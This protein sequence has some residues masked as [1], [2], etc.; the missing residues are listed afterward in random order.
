MKEKIRRI[1]LQ[2]PPITHHV[3]V[4]NKPGNLRPAIAAGILP[5]DFDI[6]DVP[7]ATPADWYKRN[8]ERC[9]EL[10]FP[11]PNYALPIQPQEPAPEIIDIDDNSDSDSDNSDVLIIDKDMASENDSDETWDTGLEDSQSDTD[12]G[13]MESDAGAG[14]AHLD[15]VDDVMDPKDQ[16]LLDMHAWR[17][18]NPVRPPP[19]IPVFNNNNN[20]LMVFKEKK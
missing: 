10:G 19:P 16:G 13:E 6:Q 14:T 12:S 4:A 8:K 2:N 11:E 1:N 15:L 20:P 18:R 9:D 5:D 7:F 3:E 17:R